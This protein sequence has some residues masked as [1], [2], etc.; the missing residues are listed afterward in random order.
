MF[1]KTTV[2]RMQHT[3]AAGILF[4]ARQFDIIH[5]VYE[6][7]MSGQSLGFPYFLNK[8]H[9]FVPIVHAEA[10]YNRPLH[11]GDKISVTLKV[12]HIGK[13]SFT[14][15]YV[16][17]NVRG[18]TVGKAETTHVAVHRKSHKKIPLPSRLRKVLGKAV[19]KQ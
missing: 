9:Y 6:D 8:A 7:F 16:L 4:F 11:V 15:S 17:K 19:R 18:Q 13:T 14:F 2:I 10:D 5:S 3:D 12:S 1:K